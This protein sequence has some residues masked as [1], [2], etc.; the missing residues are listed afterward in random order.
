MPSLRDIVL[1]NMAVPTKIYQAWSPPPP[2]GYRDHAP[3]TS[4]KRKSPPQL[5]F[6]Y[7]QQSPNKRQKSWESSFPDYRSMSS[8]DYSPAP[9]QSLEH[10]ET[11]LS[12][13]S[14]SDPIRSPSTHDQPQPTSEETPSPTYQRI[15]TSEVFRR[16]SLPHDGPFLPSPDYSPQPQANYLTQPATNQSESSEE[17]EVESVGSVAI[18]LEEAE[19]DLFELWEIPEWTEDEG[20]EC[21]EPIGEPVI[22]DEERF[23]ACL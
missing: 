10:H 12:P 18:K 11:I 21:G 7:D 14:N 8:P 17:W 9:P 16:Y 5:E 2:Y 3:T 1:A 23:L 15:T 6:D 22:E 20:D 19:E 13:T 4:T